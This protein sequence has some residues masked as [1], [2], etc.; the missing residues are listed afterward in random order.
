[1]KQKKKYYIIGIILL[2]GA[3]IGYHYLAAWQAEQ[4]IG[5]GISEQ[6]KKRKGLS[7]RYSS[8]DIAPFA[9]TVSFRD[10]TVMLGDH[11]ERAKEVELDIGY[12]DFL[13]IYLGGLQYGLDHLNQAKITSLGPSYLNKEDLEE[14][15]F[16]TLEIIYSGNALDGLRSAVNGTPF[17]HSQ[18][19][20]ARSA[21]LTLSLPQTPL[22]KVKAQTFSYTGRIKPNESYFWTQGTH[23]FSMDSL[24]W[25]P[26][27]SFQ[28]TYSFFIK[29]FGYPTDAIPF[30]HARLRS[31][32]A[33][34]A[35]TLKVTASV[36]SELA[37]FSGSGFLQLRTPLE[38]SRFRG[39]QL[40]LTDFSQS[41]SNI[42]QNIEQ[43]FSINLPRQNESIRLQLKGT[44]SKPAISH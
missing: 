14:I 32:P 10:L 31:E 26:A 12:L 37:L 6:V 35:N 4:Q 19:V 42:L 7:V 5:K 33:S 15:K 39:A 13:N 17:H 44:L 16:D 38:T 28:N 23:R 40:S 21:G 30:S 27:K 2:V 1:M 9:G 18:K 20:E 41:F 3:V 29:G 25:T 11:I 34:Q 24:Q 22:H 43:L 36:R 8:L